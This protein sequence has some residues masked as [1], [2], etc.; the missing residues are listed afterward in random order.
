[1][2]GLENAVIHSFC[3]ID[4]IDHRY[5]YTRSST[6][7]S[8][9]SRAALFPVFDLD[10]RW[11]TGM[12]PRQLDIACFS[13]WNYGD[14]SVFCY[15]RPDRIDTFTIARVVLIEQPGKASDFIH[16]NRFVDSDHPAICNP[17]PER[18]SAAT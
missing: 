11:V 15:P 1:M 9:N 13:F 12:H 16:T 4:L 14:R 6:G 7:E 3:I 17:E 2:G 5:G 18:R 10:H 8:G